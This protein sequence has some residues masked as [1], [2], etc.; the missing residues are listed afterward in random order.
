LTRTS[1]KAFLPIGELLLAKRLGR[2]EIDGHRFWM[3][4]QQRHLP[5]KTGAAA[6]C[7]KGIAF[8]AKEG[9]SHH[10]K[11]EHNR[12][13]AGCRSAQDHLLLSMM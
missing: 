1:S 8:S 10:G 5:D 7:Q 2:S 4:A 9:V 3:L 11:L 6:Q 12:L 13:A